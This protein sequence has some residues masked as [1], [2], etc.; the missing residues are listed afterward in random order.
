MNAERR[1]KVNCCS[2]KIAACSAAGAQFFF[3]AIIDDCQR[4]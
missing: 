4:E 2:R 1:N 3:I